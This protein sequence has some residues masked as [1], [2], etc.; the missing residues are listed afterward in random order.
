M[1]DRELIPKF[2]SAYNNY[3]S[4]NTPPEKS[5]LSSK[6]EET[7]KR[8]NRNYVL[9]IIWFVITF[10]IVLFTIMAIMTKKD[11]SYVMYLSL[12]FLI[13]ISFFTFKNIYMYFNVLS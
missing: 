7:S 9:L 3:L 4:L 1:S 6:V 13:F 8:V 12:G 5:E 10:I 11:N 2:Y